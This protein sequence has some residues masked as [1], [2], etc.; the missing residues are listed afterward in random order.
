MNKLKLVPEDT[1]QFP[2]FWLN[3]VASLN[4][5]NW[6]VSSGTNFNLFMDNKT[7]DNFSAE[8]LDAIYNGWSLLPLQSSRTISFG[9]IKYTSAGV[10]GRNVLTSAPKS[11]IITDGGELVVIDVNANVTKG[12]LTIEGKPV[13]AI[14]TKGFPYTL[15]ITF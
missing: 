10:S 13:S 12:V 1:F 7:S 6:N 15:P 8:N 5:G 4:I 14:G 9:T 11:W 3:D 2:M